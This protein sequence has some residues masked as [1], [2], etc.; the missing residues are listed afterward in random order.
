MPPSKQLPIACALTPDAI[1]ARRSDL[2]PGLVNQATS[3][4]LLP[5]GMR[6]QFAASSETLQT[7]ASTLDAERQCC[8]FLRFE[9]AIEQDGGPIWLTVT[10]P[11]GTA[12][13]ADF[14]NN[15]IRD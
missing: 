3:V 1:R 9:L 15:L 8:R 10:G 12:G 4:E 11:E 2:L 6:L 13:T 14:L 5:N 7:I